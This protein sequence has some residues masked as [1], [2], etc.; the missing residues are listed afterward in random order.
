MSANIKKTLDRHVSEAQY[1]KAQ[2]ML[3]SARKALKAGNTSL[4][5]TL[6]SE[7]KRLDAAFEL[8]DD[9]PELVLQE[10]E[11]AEARK[12]VETSQSLAKSRGSRDASERKE[13]SGGPTLSQ[14]Y[15]RE[16]QLTA[17][18]DTIDASLKEG[19]SKVAL[20]LAIEQVYQDSR[21]TRS[22]GQH[23]D[24]LT[25]L[26][27]EKTKLRQSFG[28]SHPQ[29][30]L[31]QQQIDHLRGLYALP[32][33][34][35]QS[36]GDVLDV[37]V[38]AL[39]GERQATRELIYKEQI[40][41]SDEGRAQFLQLLDAKIAEQKA[42]IEWNE[43]LQ[44]EIAAGT[45]AGGRVEGARRANAFL[46]SDECR[47][48]SEAIAHGDRAQSQRGLDSI[49]PLIKLFEQQLSL[50]EHAK[51]DD[52]ELAE[53]NR[54][55]VEEVQAKG[56]PGFGALAPSEY[57]ESWLADFVRNSEGT[58][59]Q[60]SLLERQRASVEKYANQH[61]TDA[62][63]REKLDA[64]IRS[65]QAQ[66]AL[67][68][69]ILQAMEKARQDVSVQHVLTYLES[70]E[71]RDQLETV[72]GGD[73]ELVERSI[74][75]SK[76]LY[77][78]LAEQHKLVKRLHADDPRVKELNRQVTRE[79][80]TLGIPRDHNTAPQDYLRILHDEAAKQLLKS[81]KELKD[82]ERERELKK[83]KEAVERR[84]GSRATPAAWRVAE[85]PDEPRLSP[86]N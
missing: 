82:L 62:G 85:D 75:I 76:R 49:K 22:L 44:A 45:K 9:R 54:K 11:Q 4:A 78:L 51:D 8:F 28:D 38:D 72:A 66:V 17:L 43:R 53:I 5:R 64:Q 79:L 48:L 37:Y 7:V 13:P 77:E 20:L 33:G 69:G 74:L 15:A 30:V 16:R 71:F 3:K 60:L 84:E 65:L 52:P 47:G 55:I 63:G 41:D 56:M 83:L 59:V 46:E 81:M 10:I 36:I 32:S 25:K 58:R 68:K 39:R 86:E 61:S 31:L 14:L 57:F 70:K 42:R 19:G 26:E 50:L 6:V 34:D 12:L 21:V 67:H 1:P 35:N 18:L 27:I 73:Q 29:V 40:F 23:L 80:D 24:Q 2:E